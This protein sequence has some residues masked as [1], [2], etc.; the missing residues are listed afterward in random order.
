MGKV[1]KAVILN[2]QYKGQ[3]TTHIFYVITLGDDHMLLGMPFLAATNPDIDWTNGE[4][5]GQ[6]HVGTTNAHKWKSEQGSK[7]EGLF[8]PDED[9]DEIEGRRAYYRT[10]KKNKDETLK[11]TTV[12]PEDY[13]FI[14]KVE[15]ENN[16]PV[17]R[18]G[19]ELALQAMQKDLTLVLYP[20][21]DLKAVYKEL[22]LASYPYANIRRTTT[23]TQIAA[24][25]ADKIICSWQKTVPRE[26]HHYGVV[27][28]ETKAQRVPTRR[29][30][31]HVIDLKP[32]APEMLD[33]KTYPLPVGQQEALDEFLKEHLKKGYIHISKSPY[34]A[35]FFFIKKKDGKLRPVQDYHKLNEYTVKNKYPIPLIKEMINQLVE[36]HWFT[37]FDIRWG[38]NN[39]RI[40]AGNEWKATFKTNRGLYEPTVMFFG[41]TNSPATFQAMM[42]TIFKEE[43]AKGNVFIYMDDILIATSGSL[44]Y[45]RQQ[46]NKVLNKLLT[47]DLFLNPKKCQFHVREVEFLG[48]IIGKGKVKMD[49]IKVKAIEEWPVLTDLHSLRSF[50]G[51]GNYYKDFIED[52][53]KLTCP[54]YDLTKKGTPWHWGVPQHIAFE[55]LKEKFTS[56]LVLRNPNPH[57]CYILDTDTS[58][59]AVG[60]TLSQDFHDGRHPIA[61]FSKSLLPAERNYDIYDQELLTIIHAIKAFCHLL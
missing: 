53:S 25:A 55:T 41:L 20:Y 17:R 2:V 35:P 5:I 40:K 28:S 7:E 36:K 37:K 23:A 11:F 22:C 59:Y 31:D 1:I 61:Y 32:D 18:R 54:L 49:P 48:A 60:T 34:A 13:T 58:L 3:Q 4:F 10:E 43:V 19:L 29:S 44:E 50:L 27:F 9:I 38:Y 33:S 42:D 12:E 52:Y 14:R 39:V 51:F 6:I 24:E 57:K 56:Y 45:H 46:V 26:Y 47:N 30:W 16:A 21:T 15:P 8:K